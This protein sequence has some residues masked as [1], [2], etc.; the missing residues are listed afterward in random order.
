MSEL[1][2]APVSDYIDRTFG[3]GG[4]LAQ[5][6][7][8]YKPRHG[9]IALAR[10]VDA[11]LRA[12]EHL[13]AEGATGVGKSVGYLVPATY[14]AS[15]SAERILS[16]RSDRK[17]P[18][19]GEDWS[20]AT[21]IVV[22]ANIALSE[23][24]VMKDL[25]MLQEVLPWDFTFSLMK[26]KNN[27]AC[28]KKFYETE[29]S[30]YDYRPTAD[31]MDELSELR[32]W[33][34]DSINGD[35][36][37][38]VSELSFEPMHRT[39]RYYSTTS[40]DCAGDKCRYYQDCFWAKAHK[41]ARASNV[42]VTNYAMLMAHLMVRSY[43]GKDLIL[44][45]FG[46]AILDEC[47]KFSDIAREALGF[48]V[49]HEAIKRTTKKIKFSD[50]APA[51][52]HASGAFFSALSD[53]KNSPSY[54]TRIKRPLEE[55]SFVWDRWSDLKYAMLQ[56]EERMKW[57][58]DR[59]Q[60]LDDR[61]DAINDLMRLQERSGELRTSLQNAMELSRSDDFIYFIERDEKGRTILVGKPIF[62]G[63]DLKK[64]LFSHANVVCASATM[65]VGGSFDFISREIGCD[66]YKE[67]VVPS[68]FLYQ[69]QALLITPDM[70][71]PND[72]E[73]RDAVA[74]AVLEVIQRTGGRTLGLFTSRKMVDYVHEKV[75]NCGY[76]V[77][78]QGMGGSKSK[79]IELFKKDVTSV[80][81]G[82]E[83]FWA[84]VDVPG[85]ALSA[86]VIDRIPF[87]NREDPVADAIS[88]RDPKWFH[89]YA[90]PKA[91]IQLK[92]GFGRLIRSIHDA[93]VVIILDRRLTTKGYG[94]IF[95][96]SLPD[97]PITKGLDRISSFLG[98]VA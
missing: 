24:L 91:A 2:L 90:I 47:H 23:Q 75:R 1:V 82:T 9:Q 70:P 85:E 95:L 88:E 7:S 55:T 97:V 20:P 12:G 10:A 18:E 62:V 4:L 17:R 40:E 64:H 59:L 15:L 3:E 16:A 41:R 58:I 44:P 31:E 76:K 30:G 45:P 49:T 34:Y 63:D 74:D 78:K 11:A 94:K 81:L 93:G 67:I 25:P 77:F 73:F 87:P 53:Y 42:V 72:L 71:E 83:S 80:L 86:V 69:E 43:T 61:A 8:A 28:L 52:E 51:L 65:C 54:V 48:K 79:L 26:G 19:E 5:K 46:T 89:N 98:A 50:E 57:E 13:M 96:K 36:C 14:H 35:G 22:T 32:Q 68:P 6:F 39:W 92:Q 21:I 56:S 33:V 27:F 37:G 60:H 66:P 29:A 38:D 84:G